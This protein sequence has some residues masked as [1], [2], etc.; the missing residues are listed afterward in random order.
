MEMSIGTI[1]T[2]V[3]SMTLLIGGIVLIKNILSSSNNVL[4]MTDSQLTSQINQFFGEGSKLVMYPNSKEV[5]TNVGETTA[6]AFG[7][8]N[9]LIGSGQ[10]NEFTYT[11]SVSDPGNCGVSESIINEW[12]ILGKSGS[13]QVTHDD[14]S[15]VRVNLYIPDSAPLCTFRVQVVV[16]N[17][18]VLYAS[19]SMDIKIDS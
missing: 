3:L 4:D 18:G 17:D 13:V 10:N 12:I 2:I 9:T 11:T 7:I 8:K 1:V 19:D 5:T 16:N 15:S 6:F 14:I